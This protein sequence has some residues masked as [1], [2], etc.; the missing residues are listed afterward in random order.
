MFDLFASYYFKKVFYSLFL[1]FIF[2]TAAECSIYLVEDPEKLMFS[3]RLP[4]TPGEQ[5]QVIFPDGRIIDMGR[6]RTI[7]I[8]S[9]H[10]GFTASKY[11][12][13]GQV[14]ATAANAHHL[15]ISV[16]DGSGRTLSLIPSQ[17]FVAAPGF[18]TSFIVEGIGGSGL[19]GEYAPYVGSPIYIINSVG[20]AVPFNNIG[21]LKFTTAVEIRV[22]RPEDEIDYLEIENWSGGRAWYH[23]AQ[24]DHQF[25]VVESG[26][27]GTGRF[28]G[29]LYQ[30]AGMV[31]ANHPGVICVSTTH[32]TDIGGFQ[33]VPINH[34]YSKE[35]QK[36]RRMAQYIILRGV[37]FDDLT[38]KPPFFRGLLRPGDSDALDSRGGHVIAKI[39][40]EWQPLPVVSGLTEDTLSD[41]EAIRIYIH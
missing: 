31:R 6:I 37:E 30:E 18:G 16:E 35:M 40:G 22:Y 20:A 41:V 19:W 32:K 10:P 5:A 8:K 23:D 15:Q 27:T 7:P 29:S 38:G 24:G 26:V 17:T 4:M 14:I 36:S 12:I 39:G 3:I 33:I 1:I 2:T 28:E 9:K 25:A 21:L 11:G 13:G 34:T